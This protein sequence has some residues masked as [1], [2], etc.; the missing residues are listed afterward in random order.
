M[1]PYPAPQVPYHGPASHHG[2]ADNKPI[3]RVVLHSTVSPC[4]RGGAENVARYFRSPEATGSAHYVVDP[5]EAVQ[6]VYDS[7]VAY[8]APPNEHSIGIEMCDQP[9]ATSAARWDDI[10]HRQLLER[11]ALL[12]A[13]LCLAYGVPVKFR[14]A[15]ALRAGLHGITT[16][17]E[18]SVAFGQSTHWDPGAWP[19]RRFMAKV[20]RHVRRLRK[21][22]L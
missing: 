9:S 11:V 12:T 15:R 8:H 17:H 22:S 10:P 18:V 6:V 4:V 13:Q 19:R 5:G 1:G 3:R 21:E 7:V 14:T 20:R 16:H 2:D